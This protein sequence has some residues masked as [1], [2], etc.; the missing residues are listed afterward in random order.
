MAVDNVTTN[1]HIV[2]AASGTVHI[3]QDV[4]KHIRLIQWVDDNQDIA[5]G[6]NLIL[7]LN[8]Q[9]LEATVQIETDKAAISGAVVWQIGPFPEKGFPA[10]SLLV[11]T[12]S[13]GQVYIFFA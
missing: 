2:T 1:P 11:G 8:G 7:T 9:A 6:S 12:M 4:T 3:W 5:D 10:K 13:A